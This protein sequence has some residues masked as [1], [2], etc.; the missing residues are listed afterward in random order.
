[1]NYPNPEG[2]EVKLVA[3]YEAYCVKCRE[4]RTMKDASVTET[5]NGRKM[6]KG[7]CPVCGTTMNKFLPSSQA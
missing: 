5:K 3:E 1:M 4:K 2:K 6:A 7:K